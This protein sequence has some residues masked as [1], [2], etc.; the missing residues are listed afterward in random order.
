MNKRDSK[1][2]KDSLPKKL[3]NKLKRKLYNKPNNKRKKK[4]K[5]FLIQLNIM[6]TDQTWSMNLK[7]HLKHILIHINSMLKWIFHNLL[8]N[9]ILFVR[10]EN[11]LNKPLQLLVESPISE[12]KV[13]I[14]SFMI[15]KDKVKDFKLCVTLTTI[16]VFKPLL[17]FILNS[18][19]VILSV[20]SV[21]QV[22]QIEENSQLLQDKFSFFHHASICYQNHMSVLRINNQDIERDI[23]I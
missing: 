18:E 15:W 21:N 12:P 13:K 11:F 23:L 10:K 22:E 9:S 3:K 20:L 19:E 2:K 7:N 16:K 14:L 17:K 4:N 8:P 1:N 6:K 5:L